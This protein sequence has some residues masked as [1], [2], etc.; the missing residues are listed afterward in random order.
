MLARSDSAR[1]TREG[2]ASDQ[3]RGNVHLATELADLILE[4]FT[5]RLDQLEAVASHQALGNAADVVVSLD[6][7]GRTLERDTLD[8]VCPTW[9]IWKHR[10]ESCSVLTRVE[11]ALQEELNLAVALGLDLLG[12]RLE[13]IDELATDELA[14]LLGVELALQTSQE[15]LA[16]INDGEVDTQLILENLLDQLALVETHAAVVNKNGVETVANGLGHQLGGNGGVDTTADSTENLT[17]R[18]DEIADTLDLLTDELGHS[19]VLR[20]IADTNGEVLQ[21]LTTL[22]GVWNGSVFHNGIGAE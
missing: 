7:L 22:R 10:M 1:L 12:L 11:S 17:L 2:V 3:L 8:D 14:L 16:S 9:L 19:P 15:L 4:Q 6:S 18:A 13:D 20:S 21:K 5:Q